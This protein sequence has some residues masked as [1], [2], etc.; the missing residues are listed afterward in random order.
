MKISNLH[1]R[2]LTGNVSKILFIISAIIFLFFQSEILT[3]RVPLVINNDREVLR[4]NPDYKLKRMSTGKVI[5]YSNNQNGELVRHEFENVYA[6]V[7][8]GAYRRQSIDQLIPIL[9]RKYYFAED[10]CRREIKHAV[11]VLE[12]WNIILSQSIKPL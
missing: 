4:I 12:E 8:L 1:H 11:H 6:D 3:A 5:I 2:I 9:S 10:E 7:L